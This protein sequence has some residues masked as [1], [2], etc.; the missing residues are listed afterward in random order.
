LRRVRVTVVDVEYR[1]V[2]MLYVCVCSLVLVIQHAQRMRR[3]TL[4]PG[5]LPVCTISLHIIS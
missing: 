3:T 4:S 2:K 5:D 1:Y